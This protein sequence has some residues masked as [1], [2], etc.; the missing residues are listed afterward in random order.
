MKNVLIMVLFSSLILFFSCGKGDKK[1]EPTSQKDT[2][3]TVSKVDFF[4]AV[5]DGD[6][7]KVK[8]YLEKDKSL[9]NAVD[10]SNGINET[11]LGIVTFAGNKELTEL[12]IKNGAN[13]NFQDAYGVAPIHGAARTN[14]LDVIKVLLENKADINLPTTTGKET[15]LHYA[16]RFNNPDVVKYLLDKG[17]KKDDKDASGNTPYEAAKKENADK[18]LPLLK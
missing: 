12:L 3:T 4:K 17:A 6:V 11:A 7:A 13:V 2:K 14:K 8:E 16:A 5:K 10:S 15:P 1:S 9:V 18:V